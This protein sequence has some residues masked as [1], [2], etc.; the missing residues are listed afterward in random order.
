METVTEESPCNTA[1]GHGLTEGGS[2]GGESA[3]LSNS[4]N[5]WSPIG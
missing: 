5:E 1:A 2:R 3:E 4:M